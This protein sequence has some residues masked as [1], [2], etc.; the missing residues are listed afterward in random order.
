MTQTKRR[1]DLPEEERM[2]KKEGQ[3]QS[4]ASPGNGAILKEKKKKK[5]KKRTHSDVSTNDDEPWM[6]GGLGVAAPPRS[7]VALQEQSNEHVIE[8]PKKKKPKYSHTF[9]HKTEAQSEEEPPVT[10]T[11]ISRAYTPILPPVS[12]FARKRMVEVQ[13]SE[14]VD[15]TPILPAKYTLSASNEVGRAVQPTTFSTPDDDKTPRNFYTQGWENTVGYVRATLKR[16]LDEE[17]QAE[18]NVAFSNMYL[19]DPAR[20]AAGIN[21]AGVNFRTLNMEIGKM[22]KVA[23]PIEQPALQICV[24]AKGRVT[25]FLDEQKFDIEVGGV[26]RVKTSENCTVKGKR[27]SIIYITSIPTV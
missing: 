20:C 26:W 22:Y 25:V 8:K 14:S 4:S 1:W 24:V 19:R 12:P 23:T 17:S 10:P 2:R 18:E 7:P 6:I 9:E 11:K 3:P 27:F 21:I 5:K 13:V 16:S 15:S